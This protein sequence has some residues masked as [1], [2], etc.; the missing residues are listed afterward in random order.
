MK[1]LLGALIFIFLAPGAAR[2]VEFDASLLS[3]CLKLST[4]PDDSDLQQELLA[5]PSMQLISD[6]LPRHSEISVEQIAQQKARLA[7]YAETIPSLQAELPALAAQATDFAGDDILL[8]D[9]S[10]RLICGAP[11]DAFGFQ[12]DGQFYLFLNLPLIAPDFMPHLLRHELWHVAYRQEYPKVSEAFE[13]SENAMKNLAY[14]MLN[15]GVGHYYSFRRR[16]EPKIVY[17]NWQERTDALFGLTKAKTAE[18]AAATSKQQQDELLWTSE[19]GVPFWRKWGATTGAVITYRLN[20]IYGS[21]GMKQIVASGP[22]G[23]LRAYNSEAQ[24][25]TGWQDLPTALVTA[26]C[27]LDQVTA[28]KPQ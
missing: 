26:A 16:V 10:I 18:L 17:D 6:N 14:I 21:T 27:S 25:N 11:Y 8:K 22:C 28:G 20:S 4:S 2:G 1:Y 15:E 7:H 3:Q 24:N 9:Q 19:A 12:K 23:F 5:H 13:Q